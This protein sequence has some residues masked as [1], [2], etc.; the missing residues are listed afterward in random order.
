MYI[1]YILYVLYI[2]AAGI[3]DCMYTVI[4]EPYTYLT[5]FNNDSTVDEKT[6]YRY[7]CYASIFLYQK[8]VCKKKKIQ[9]I[10]VIFDTIECF[11]D[12]RESK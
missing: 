12:Q 10:V 8:Y 3:F 4:V 11:R 1:Y 5:V 9:K 2:S 7:L 6:T